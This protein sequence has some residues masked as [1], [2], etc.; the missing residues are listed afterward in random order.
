MH[1]AGA[2][3]LMKLVWL[4]K[5]AYFQKPRDPVKEINRV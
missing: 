2:Q 1:N 3:S 5:K 4:S